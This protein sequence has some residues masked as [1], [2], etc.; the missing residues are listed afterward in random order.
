MATK[1]QPARAR[2]THDRP[3]SALN[4]RLV[5][6]LFGLV[7]SLLFAVLSADADLPVLTVIFIALAVVAVIDLVIVQRRRGARRREEPGARP[8]LFE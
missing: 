3:Y 7:F 1:S 6:A 2:G 8:S 5:L 4:L